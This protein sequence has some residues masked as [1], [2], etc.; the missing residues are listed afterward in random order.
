MDSNFPCSV[1]LSTVE[2][3]TC[4]RLSDSRDNAQVKCMRKNMSAWSGKM[5]G[6]LLPLPSFLPFYVRVRTFSIFKI[7]L[8]RSLGQA[9]NCSRTFDYNSILLNRKNSF[10][11]FS[12]ITVL[13]ER[14]TFRQRVTAVLQLLTIGHRWLPTF[15]SISLCRRPFRTCTTRA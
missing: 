1:L 10:L 5:S 2:M 6:G 7:R 12:L 4:S 11:F 3:I 13:I 9:S 15:S 8:S 14:N